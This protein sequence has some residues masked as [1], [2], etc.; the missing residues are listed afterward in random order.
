MA[1]SHLMRGAALAALALAACGTDQAPDPLAPTTPTGRVRFVTLI[2]D[3]TKGRVN[4]TLE[5]VPFGVNLTYTGTTPSSL[6][7]PATAI[8]S[9]IYSG[10]RSLVLKRTADTTTTIG[11]Y[12]FN[13]TAGL[14]Y[15]IFAVGGAGATPVSFAISTDTGNGAPAAG[16]VKIRLMNFNVAAG[17]LDVFVTAVG[18]DLTVATPAIAGLAVLGNSAYLSFAAGALQ[19]RAVPAG[20]APASRPAAVNHTIS[21][22]TLAAGAVRSYVATENNIGGLPYRFGAY[23]DR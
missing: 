7:S 6:P 1:H 13:V 8:Y 17:A 5:G 14:D 10:A 11:T 9:P 12:N 15:T 18:A 3:T 21:T 19:V 2:N 22:G 16:Q 4:A 23:I 20:T